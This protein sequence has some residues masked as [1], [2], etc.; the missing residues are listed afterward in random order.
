MKKIISFLTAVLVIASTSFSAFAQSA[1][2]K[3]T[4]SNQQKGAVEFVTKGVASYNLDNA[5]EYSD[6]AVSGAD[7]SKFNDAFL[8]DVKANLEKNN[9][10]LI[11]TYGESLATYGSVVLILDSAGENPRDFY[12]YDIV[13]AFTSMDPAGD[14]GSSYYYRIII[15]ALKLLGEDEFALKVCDALIDKYYVMGSGMDNWG[16]SCDNDGQFITALAPYAENYPDVI[17]DAFN[18]IEKYESDGGYFGDAQWT[19]YVNTCST[20][21]A[22]MA[23]SSYAYYNNDEKSFEKANAI[24]AD[25][26]TFESSGNT[27][28]FLDSYSDTEDAYSTRNALV[29]LNEY[30]KALELF[31]KT[32]DNTATTPADDNKNENQ[33]TTDSAV[34]ETAAEKEVNDSKKSPNTGASITAVSLAFAIAMGAGATVITKRKEK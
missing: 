21:L 1:P 12:D 31:A 4:V 29:G 11:S 26:C 32:E 34:T 17:A 25:L 27:G 24:Y 5:V 9:G 22:F 8:A 20:A 14:A 13:K 33:Q 2:S 7:I 30:A 18:C 28:V 16:F 23:Y 15:S 3:E 19:P 10:K 6:Y